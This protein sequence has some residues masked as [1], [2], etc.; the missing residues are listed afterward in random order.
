[1]KPHF[2]NKIISIKSKKLALNA[3]VSEKNHQRLILFKKGISDYEEE[4]LLLDQG[5]LRSNLDGFVKPE[6]IFEFDKIYKP[7]PESIGC[8]YFHSNYFSNNSIF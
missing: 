8:N 6:N 7:N 3:L 2:I 4:T 1:M 5:K